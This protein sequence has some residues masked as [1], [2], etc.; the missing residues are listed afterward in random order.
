[1]LTLAQ[2][3]N[4]DSEYRMS[5]FKEIIEKIGKTMKLQESKDFAAAIQKKPFSEQ[6]TA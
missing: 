3:E 5:D 2:K 6:Q 4:E 1:V